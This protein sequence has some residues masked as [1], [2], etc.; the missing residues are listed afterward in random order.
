MMNVVYDKLNCLV[1]LRV[2]QSGVTSSELPILT[3]TLRS[4]RK[5]SIET[6]LFKG[7]FFVVLVDKICPTLSSFVIISYQKI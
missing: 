3:T 5:S 4:L 1:L 7:S 2:V 6:E